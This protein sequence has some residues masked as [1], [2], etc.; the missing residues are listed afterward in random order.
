MSYLIDTQIFIWAMIS[1]EKLSEQTIEILQ[2]HSIYVS[3][4]SFFEI[5]I[6]QKIGKLPHFTGYLNSQ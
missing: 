6:K 4:I 1:P 2:H 5:T 3:Q